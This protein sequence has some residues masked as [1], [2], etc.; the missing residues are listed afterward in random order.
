MTVGDLIELLAEL[1]SNLDVVA[2][3]HNKSVEHVIQIN[4]DTVKIL[5]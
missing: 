1:D 2:G 3:V 5:P 4:A